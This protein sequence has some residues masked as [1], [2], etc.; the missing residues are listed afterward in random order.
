M[1]TTVKAL[2]KGR[3]SAFRRRSH[4]VYRVIA[5][6][7]EGVPGIVLAVFSIIVTGAIYELSKPGVNS[8]RAVQIGAAS[9]ALTVLVTIGSA[10]W[11]LR[12]MPPSEYAQIAITGEEASVVLQV[13]SQEILKACQL[14][15]RDV[16]AF[17]STLRFDEV[18]LFQRLTDHLC[19]IWS[20]LVVHLTF[21]SSTPIVRKDRLYTR[22]LGSLEAKFAQRRH[23]LIRRIE[24]LLQLGSQELKIPRLRLQD[25]LFEYDPDIHLAYVKRYIHN[26][27]SLRSLQNEVELLPPDVY[28]AAKE[29]AQAPRSSVN[30]SGTT[31]PIVEDKVKSAKAMLDRIDSID[32]ENTQSRDFADTA[33]TSAKNML[34]YAALHRF[35][36][37]LAA[38]HS[39]SQAVKEYAKNTPTQFRLSPTQ[40]TV[41]PSIS[42]RTVVPSAEGDSWMEFKLSIF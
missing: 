40:P 23:G 34:D 17:K 5:T 1:G 12:G 9:F 33:I 6:G 14:F 20:S 37:H 8:K 26:L 2:R 18:N 13:L 41:Q 3:K 30:G 39:T 16:A 10:I 32:R 24:A 19:H 15:R 38:V 29:M 31:R 36:L 28:E 35:I 11:A 21:P 7:K 25:Q 22:N 42:K 4:Q 27:S